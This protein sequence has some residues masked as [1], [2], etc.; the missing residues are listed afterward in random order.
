MRRAPGADLIPLLNLLR[1]L[2]LC[3]EGWYYLVVMGFV[4]GGALMRQIN[5]L[6]LLFGI[7]VGPFLFNLWCVTTM[8]RGIQVRRRAV[9]W[10]GAGDPLIVDLEVSC[11]GPRGG[12]LAVMV[13]DQIEQRSYLG[14]RIK[15]SPAVLFTRL[16]PGESRTASY[17][18][19]LER[20][21]VYRFGPVYVSTRFPFGLVKYQIEL[22]VPGEILIAPPL[23]RLTPRWHQLWRSSSEDRVDKVAASQRTPLEGDFHGL[24]PWHSGDS[25]RWIHWR[26]TARTQELMVRQFEQP[27]APRWILFVE[28]WTP[29]HPTAADRQRVEDVVSFVATVA[30]EHSRGGRGNLAIGIASQEPVVIALDAANALVEVFRQLAR[31]QA[32]MVDRSTELASKLADVIRPS[33]RLLVATTRPQ[34]LL[35]GPSAPAWAR[36]PEWSPLA[37][38]AVAFDFDSPQVDEY[39]IAPT[40]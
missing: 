17:R 2:S 3:R 20:R 39:W 28:L 7:L 15:H 35:T 18:G 4:A 34:P 32:T 12:A 14:P 5:L 27:R 33:S 8:F 6:L 36:T 16:T 31:A 1:R 21:G 30:A 38:K 40:E 26:T 10:A 37:A 13:Q 19:K 29:E 24:R 11:T 25:I 22:D 23:G 9:E